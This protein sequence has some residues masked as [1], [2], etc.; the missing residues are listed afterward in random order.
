MKPQNQHSY[1]QQ[2][3]ASFI[4]TREHALCTIN[5]LYPGATT[6]T[7][8]QF[9]VFDYSVDHGKLALFVS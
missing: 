8:M 9:D 7:T 3:K 6:A 4:G 5:E 2:T 1:I